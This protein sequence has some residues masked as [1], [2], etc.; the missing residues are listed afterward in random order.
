M[1]SISSITD[2]VYYQCQSD[3]INQSNE[4]DEFNIDVK[5]EEISKM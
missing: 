3:Q 2:I 5:N 1:N 4:F